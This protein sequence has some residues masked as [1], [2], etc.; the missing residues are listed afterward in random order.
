MMTSLRINAIIITQLLLILRHNSS[1]VSS[2]I[3]TAYV[4]AI[5]AHVFL[6]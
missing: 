3:L 6:D 2:F 1:A 5:I 4:R